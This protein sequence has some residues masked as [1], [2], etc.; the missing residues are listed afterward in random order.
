M[1]LMR[2]HSGREQILG[3]P[4]QAGVNPPE[5]IFDGFN[6]AFGRCTVA[7]MRRKGK[8]RGRFARTEA[9]RRF[10]FV[11]EVGQPLVQPKW[12]VRIAPCSRC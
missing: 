11:N 8:R 2:M 10:L 5:T 6:M 4:R 7:F 12:I 9:E 3:T 1:S